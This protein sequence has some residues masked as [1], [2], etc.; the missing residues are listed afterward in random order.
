[1]YF[2]RKYTENKNL[3]PS[4]PFVFLFFLTLLNIVCMYCMY[5]ISFKFDL[6]KQ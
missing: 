2:G 1:M 5:Y 6:P 3:Y 4:N